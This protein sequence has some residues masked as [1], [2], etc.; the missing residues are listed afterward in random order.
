MSPSSFFS[1]KRSGCSDAF[2]LIRKLSP[3]SLHCHAHSRA[4]HHDVHARAS[5]RSDTASIASIVPSSSSSFARRESVV[6]SGGRQYA[7]AHINVELTL[8]RIRARGTLRA[9]RVVSLR[10]SRRSRA[11]WCVVCGDVGAV[12]RQSASRT[13]RRDVRRRLRRPRRLERNS[14]AVVVRVRAREARMAV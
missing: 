12:G 2:V 3:A 8:C 14:R 5:T 6:V 1:L 13:P 7:P 9:V 4:C 11:G 10:C